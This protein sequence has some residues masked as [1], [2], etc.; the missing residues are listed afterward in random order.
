[1]K[2]QNPLLFCSGE[3]GRVKMQVLGK[4]EFSTGGKSSTLADE[5]C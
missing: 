4:F 5:H 3:E 1:M 2:R